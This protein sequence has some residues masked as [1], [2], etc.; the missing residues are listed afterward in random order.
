MLFRNYRKRRKEELANI[1]RD[2]ALCG[3]DMRVNGHSFC[4]REAS[5]GKRR[6]VPAT[7]GTLSRKYEPVHAKTKVAVPGGK[8][9]NVMSQWPFMTVSGAAHC[10]T[11]NTFQ[12]IF[13]VPRFI[14]P[15]RSIAGGVEF[16]TRLPCVEPGPSVYVIL[17][18]RSLFPWVPPY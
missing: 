3:Q 9:I 17:K 15:S 14:F 11:R 4:L 8:S 2:L 10:F 6:P 1:A 12:I 18:K 13:V 7:N 5:R 16:L